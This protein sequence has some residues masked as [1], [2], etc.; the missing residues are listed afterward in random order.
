MSGEHHEGDPDGSRSQSRASFRDGVR[1]AV[2]IVPAVAPFGMMFGAVA[3]GGGFDWVQ[4]MTMAALVFAGASQMAAVQLMNE[5]APFVVVVATAAA[6]NM[7]L[8]MYSA[9][10][11]PW[12]Q[13]TPRLWR[14][15]AAGI[16]QDQSYAMA[17][18]R[19]RKKPD[20]TPWL[21]LL[22]YLGTAV[23]VFGIWFPATITGFLLGDLIPPEW[24][25]DVM[26]ALVFLG[27][28]APMINGRP[29]VVATLVSIC[30]A[31]LAR[32]LPFRG[33][34][35]VATSCGIAAG[36][37]AERLGQRRALPEAGE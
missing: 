24:R 22:Y 33:G 27:L 18:S 6:I 21:R 28:A 20:P 35:I 19:Y 25:L 23:P 14:T 30:V 15:L 3:A 37:L 9:S 26:I 10:L 32:D 5:G 8:A 13:G 7:R 29:A 4:T 16:L 36:L 2:P 17:M 34:L 1:D 11:V 12:L 31:V